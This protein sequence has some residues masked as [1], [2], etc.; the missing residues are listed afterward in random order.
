MPTF[1]VMQGGGGGGGEVVLGPL[2]YP[3]YAGSQHGATQSS[4][5]APGWDASPLVVPPPTKCTLSGRTEHIIKHNDPDM[6]VIS[7]VKRAI[8]Q[9]SSLVW[10]HVG[11]SINSEKQAR[12]T[13]LT[14]FKHFSL[15]VGRK[16]CI[17]V[18][19]SRVK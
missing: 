13:D 6:A 9:F 12:H 2:V 16:Y 17:R 8:G 7:S 1:L 15:P 3:A 19:E 4:A 11:A 5:T 14:T 18:C 10:L